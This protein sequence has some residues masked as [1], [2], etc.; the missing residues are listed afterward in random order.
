MIK[1]KL[2]FVFDNFGTD[3]HFDLARKSG[4]SGS[5]IDVETDLDIN[6]G[7]NEK[8]YLI[9]FIEHLELFEFSKIISCVHK[10]I[11]EQMFNDICTVVDDNIFFVYSVEYDLN[12]DKSVTRN[13]WFNLNGDNK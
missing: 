13:L 5:C 11:T 10:E 7:L 9:R 8:F 6:L 2:H 4:F 1:T 3:W 12:A